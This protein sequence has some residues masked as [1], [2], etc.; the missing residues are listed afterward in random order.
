MQLLLATTDAKQP[1]YLTLPLGEPLAEWTDRTIVELPVGVHRHVVRFLGHDGRL[2][3]LKELPPP[4]AHREWDLLRQLRDEGLP[5]VEVLG[6]ISERGDGLDDI[7]ITQHL[8]FSLPLRFLFARSGLPGLQE[9]LVDSVAV[10]LVRLHL[11]GF[12]WGDCSLSNI[13]FR[14]DAGTLSAWLVDAETGERHESLT[15][16]QRTLELDIAQVNILGGLLDLEAGGQL[17]A[18]LD[19]TFVADMVRSRY[20]DLWAELTSEQAIDISERHLIDARLR[21]LNDLGF[22]TTEV[23]IESSKAG[24]LVHF[25]PVVVEA[26]HHQRL[27]R[28]LTGIE[29]LENQSRRLMNDL[30]SYGAW[31]S[32]QEGHD[33]PDA[34]A[35]YRWLSDVFE[36]ALAAIPEEL[37][38]RRE[39]AELFHE[40]LEHRDSLVEA[41]HRAVRVPEAAE[42]YAQFALPFAETEQS[43]VDDQP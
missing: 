30:R 18:D 12:W 1:D 15:D 26:G 2:F 10:L 3:A 6:V 27:L 40:I 28:T 8:Q 39:A 5:V 19:P 35:S 13:L 43:V 11:S 37:R 16:G 22:D 42:S 36:P 17:A 24:S 25:K 31:L 20:E 23:S 38:D 14:R 34:V 9:S 41:R 21:R 32:G 33:L 29:A 7:L 4:L